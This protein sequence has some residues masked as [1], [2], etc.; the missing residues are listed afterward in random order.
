MDHQPLSCPMSTLCLISYQN[1]CR[2]GLYGYASARN[3]LDL[4]DDQERDSESLVQAV[5]SLAVYRVDASASSC[6]LTGNGH[7]S[8][9]T[10]VPGRYTCNQHNN[11]KYFSEQ[12][13]QTVKTFT[14]SKN[15]F[16]K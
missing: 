13:T 3:S 7:V 6:L 2:T 9:E 4:C 1:D 12:G 14:R 10:R 8:S 15:Y 5:S 16:A 11:V